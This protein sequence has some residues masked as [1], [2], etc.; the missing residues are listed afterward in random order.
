[1]GI[2]KN[3]TQYY[4]EIFA[5]P[6]ILR[7]PLLTIGFQE[8][9]DCEDVYD[10]YYPSL[11]DLLISK[12]V[13]GVTVL[14]P[15]DPRA[16]LHNDLNLPIPIDQYE[17][18]NV[19]MDIGSLEHIFDTRQVFE[20]C[21]KM[22]SIGGLYFL[23]TPVNGYMYHGLHVFSPELITEAFRLNGFDIVYLRYSSKT[24]VSLKDPAEASDSLIWIVGRKTTAV[25]TFK[26]PQQAEF[27]TY[28]QAYKKRQTQEKISIKV[29]IKFWVKQIC[30]PILLRLGKSFFKR[31]N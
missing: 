4:R 10:F 22:V 11:K 17:K 15:F 16:D 13:E 8:I 5:L 1:M 3:H 27:F 30:P 24:G 23:H 26:V 28:Y 25:D 19:L 31:N 2:F 20:N 21:M 12:N 14:D 7:G 6:N 18:Y 29:K 9:C